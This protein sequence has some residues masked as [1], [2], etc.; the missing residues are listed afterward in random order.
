MNVLIT[1]ATGLVGQALVA[2]LLKEG[3]NVNYLSISR[4]K[5]SNRLNYRG[6]Y[7][8]PEKQEIDEAAFKDVSVIVHLAGASVS[9]KWTPTY[10]TEILQSRIQT[11]RL[12]FDT[13]SRIPN[14]VQHIVS[15]SA[16]GGYKSSF[17]RIYHEEDAIE[18][19]S[20]LGDVVRAWEHEV[21]AFE[22]LRIS[23]AK[24]RIGLVLSA[25]GGA[26][27]ELIKPIKLGV[28]SPLGSGKQYQSWIHIEDLA[29]LFLFIIQNQEK[30]I[31]NGV[32]P[33]PVT[34]SELTKAIAKVLKKPFFF[35]RIPVFVLKALL[36][37]MHELLISSQHVS[38]L[39]LLN[40][41]FQFKY[42]SLE[43]ALQSL[44]K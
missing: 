2:I 6:F 9:K 15:A 23:V 22:K 11:T 12:L 26:L 1:G 25:H 34:N 40:K 39:K 10:K 37:E 28:G 21:D 33:H 31:Y 44:V 43:K 24:I 35:P 18:E 19:P 38:C 4:T 3:Y 7:W 36:G 13:L 20:F 30:G 8:N 32:S 27:V 16:I 5:L 14:Q 41:G 42:A 29:S 17:D